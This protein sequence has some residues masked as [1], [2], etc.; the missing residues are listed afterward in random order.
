MNV[1]GNVKFDINRYNN[2]VTGVFLTYLREEEIKQKF[3]MQ[4]GYLPKKDYITIKKD[5]LIK[6]GFTKKQIKQALVTICSED[7]LKVKGN[8]YFFNGVK[9]F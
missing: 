8:K 3:L 1:W 6:F 5:D 9:Y 4:Q 7:N 2:V